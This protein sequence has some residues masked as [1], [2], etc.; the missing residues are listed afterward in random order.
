M[1]IRGSNLIC[2]KSFDDY[3]RLSCYI[4]YDLFQWFSNFSERDTVKPN[5]QFRDSLGTTELI[6]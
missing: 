5:L 3:I 4:Y 1:L 6:Q 2:D